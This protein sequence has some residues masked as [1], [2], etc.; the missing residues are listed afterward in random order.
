M[1]GSVAVATAVLIV[2][3]TWHAVWALPLLFVARRCVVYRLRRAL[4]GESWSF[5]LYL[6]YV[7]RTG[8]GL[9][10]MTLLIVLSPLIVG[11]ADAGVARWGVACALGALLGL[12]QVRH[13]RVL[14]WLW[15]ATPLES[16]EIN[17]TPGRGSM[18]TR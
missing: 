4:L 11:A 9:G 7:L 6:S 1:R 2:F 15:R 16:V 3:W 18:R 17:D 5:S 8:I 10:V 13:A 14:L 12:W